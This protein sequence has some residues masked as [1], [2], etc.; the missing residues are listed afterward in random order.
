MA[1]DL[2]HM[3]RNQFR[4]EGFGCNL[5]CVYS[6]LFLLI[7]KYNLGRIQFSDLFYPLYA[8]LKAGDILNAF[9]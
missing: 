2:G 7:T 3:F 6:F 8:S 1:S 4:L 5:G 9:R